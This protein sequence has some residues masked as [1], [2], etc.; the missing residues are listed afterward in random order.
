MRV[1]QKGK[2][3]KSMQIK[4]IR[5]L[6]E[7]NSLQG[8]W[9]ALVKQGASDVPFLRHEY[10]STWWQTLGGGEW[11]EAE[12]FVVTGRLPDGSLCGIAPLF[13][14]RNRSG[15][16]ALLLLGSIEI[17][18][19]LDLIVPSQHISTFLD[20]LFSY[21]AG[22]N[23]PPWKV[24][25]LY[26]IID[27]SPIPPA[28][29]EAAMRHG[30][31]Y[32]QEPLQHCP[33]I[34]IPG[35]WEAYLASIDKKQRHEIRR[36]IRR[37][38]SG[39]KPT[40]WYI[41]QDEAEISSGVEDFMDMMA[42]DQAKDHFLSEA[43]RDQFRLSAMAAF[44]AGY[45]QLAFLEIGGEKAAGYLNFDY[46]NNL[47]I[48]NSALNFTYWDYSPGWVLLGYLLEWANENKRKHFDFMRGDEDYKYRFGAIDRRVER[49][50]I[51]R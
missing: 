22:V 37:A 1:V 12:L 46:D 4:V 51:R 13:Y 34:P 45:L 16:P 20:A 11:S 9:N 8:E 18:D 33:Y 43:M 24:L 47:W 48:Y 44:R 3:G 29:Q 27:S 31:T 38:E 36:K 2:F 28:L 7:M 32:T 21:L 25:D 40:R 50:I 17:S 35:D 39:F 6:E 49:I 10:L 19:Y 23:S 42:Q 41:V 15:E 26:N 14:S 5:T 30:W